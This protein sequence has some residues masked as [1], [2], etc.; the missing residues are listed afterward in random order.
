[1]EFLEAHSNGMRFTAWLP[2]RDDP[3]V[4][5]YYSIGGGAVLPGAIP[6]DPDI[7]L[8]HNVVQPFPFSSGAELLAQ[9]EATGLSIATLVLRNEGA[10]RAQGETEA[11]LDSVIDAMSASIDRGLKEEGLL[12][13]G[14]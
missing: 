10:W 11:F 7:P 4:R 13:G 9:G 8:G 3:L 1:G 12:S 5:D 6:A 2:G 14:L